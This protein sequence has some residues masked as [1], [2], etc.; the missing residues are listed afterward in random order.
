MQTL[1]PNKNDEADEMVVKNPGLN[2]QAAWTADTNKA[3]SVHTDTAA[4]LA[5][6]KYLRGPSRWLRT[7][8]DTNVETKSDSWQH[9]M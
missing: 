1:K 3:V 6:Y 4:S 7:Q 2:C 9:E 5:G 8:F